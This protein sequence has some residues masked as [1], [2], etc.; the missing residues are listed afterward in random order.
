MS[1][2][3]CSAAP[4]LPAPL[5]HQTAADSVGAGGGAEVR[6]GARA[7]ALGR[8]W[9]GVW[10]PKVRRQAFSN[11]HCTATWP[12]RRQLQFPKTRSFWTKHIPESLSFDVL[13]NERN[14]FAE[15]S[16]MDWTSNAGETQTLSTQHLVSG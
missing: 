10:I 5:V 2:L 15:R 11:P 1:P 3:S 7:E 4:R 13:L 12:H 16:T 8:L 14:P 6:R 9:E